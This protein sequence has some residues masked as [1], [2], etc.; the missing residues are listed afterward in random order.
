MRTKLFSG[1]IFSCCM[2]FDTCVLPDRTENCLDVGYTLSLHHVL[3][4]GIQIYKIS[5]V[6]LG[7]VCKSIGRPYTKISASWP[8]RIMSIYVSM[9]SHL[10][11]PQICLHIY[12]RYECRIRTSA[13]HTCKLEKDTRKPA[14]ITTTSQSYHMYLYMY[15]IVPIVLLRSKHKHLCIKKQWYTYGWRSVHYRHSP[16]SLRIGKRC[17]CLYDLYNSFLNFKIIFVFRFVK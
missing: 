2:T 14:T 4:I 8:W 5:R 10:R 15:V 16:V 3:F 12:K 9:C 17:A 11:R 13:S 6:G 1:N 7:V